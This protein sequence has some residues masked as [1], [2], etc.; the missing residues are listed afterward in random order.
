MDAGR[1]GWVSGEIGGLWLGT[2]ASV[3]PC[4]HAA[5]IAVGFRLSDQTWAL[6]P[7]TF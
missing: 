1:Q 2:P 6:L 3:D 7:L 5:G 4:E